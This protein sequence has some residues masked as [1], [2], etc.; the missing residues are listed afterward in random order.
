MGNHVYSLTLTYNTIVRVRCALSEKDP[1]LPAAGGTIT[2]QFAL[3]SF[4][5]EDDYKPLT[6]LHSTTV[7][8]LSNQVKLHEKR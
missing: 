6:I 1:S 5:R 4:I 7:Q 3:G 8:E 2:V